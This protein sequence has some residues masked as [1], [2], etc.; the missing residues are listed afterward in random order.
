MRG[1]IGRVEFAVRDA[2]S[3][4]HQLN[5]AGLQRPAV[6]EAVAMRQGTLQHVAENFHVAVR[7]RAEALSAGDA[8]VV[9]D[10]QRPEAHVG[11]IEVIG[12]RERVLRLQPAV[13]GLA[14]FL[15]LAK[16]QGARVD[17][18]GERLAVAGRFHQC[19]FC[20]LRLTFANGLA[21]LPLKA[22]S[23]SPGRATL[24]SRSFVD[25]QRALRRD[26]NG[27]VEPRPTVFGVRSSGRRRP[28]TASA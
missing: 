13:I 18:H 24:W 14:A 11:G 28:P 9:D 17:L 10:P 6:A 3:G 27:S 1:L 7:M 15:G 2:P 21:S 16:L 26:A 25:S 4:A 12:K 5:L 22:T 23:G 8:I 19:H 20:G